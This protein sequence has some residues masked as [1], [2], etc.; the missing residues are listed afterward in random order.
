MRYAIQIRNMHTGIHELF[1][2]EDKETA[3]ELNELFKI[4][5][6]TVDDDFMW[7]QINILEYDHVEINFR[8]VV[9]QTYQYWDETIEILNDHK[10]DIY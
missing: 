6:D 3:K 8:H 9:N 2:A 7:G 10:Y 4:L 5:A 1:I